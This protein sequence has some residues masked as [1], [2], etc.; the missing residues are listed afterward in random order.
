MRI[1][2]GTYLC[3]DKLTRTGTGTVRKQGHL[4]ILVHLPEDLPRPLSGHA[5]Q[6]DELFPT[7]WVPGNTERG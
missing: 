5:V 3:E 6:Q 4:T 2:I 1:R 7:H